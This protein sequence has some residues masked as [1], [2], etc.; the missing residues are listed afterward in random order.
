MCDCIQKIIQETERREYAVNA[1][2]GA[3]NSQSSGVSFRPITLA[4]IPH[5]HHRYIS[6][7]WKYCP[8]CGQQI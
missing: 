7:S 6:T 8:F 5:K 3:S 1:T 4:G 2:V